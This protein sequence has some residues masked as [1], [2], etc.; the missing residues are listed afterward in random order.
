LEKRRGRD[1]E[2]KPETT[3][4]RWLAGIAKDLQGD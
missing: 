2:S 1:L 3:I 4:R